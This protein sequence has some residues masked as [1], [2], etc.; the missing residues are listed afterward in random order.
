MSIGFPK[1]ELHPQ[2]D[3]GQRIRAERRT[4]IYVTYLNNFSS[5]FPRTNPKLFLKVINDIIGL[6]Y[7]LF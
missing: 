3:I 6:N 4:P 5:L 2:S 7:R 1:P